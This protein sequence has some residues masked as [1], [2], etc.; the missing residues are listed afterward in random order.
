MRIESTQT[1]GGQPK[2]I[3][4]DETASSES[5]EKKYL[6]SLEHSPRA[7]AHERQGPLQEITTTKVMHPCETGFHAYPQCT[8]T[9]YKTTGKKHT[10][11]EPLAALPLR[12]NT[13]AGTVSSPSSS[14]S[15]S[16]LPCH[17]GRGGTGGGARGHVNGDGHL[18]PPRASR[19]HKPIFT[20]TFAF[21]FT[22]TFAPVGLRRRNSPAP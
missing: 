14:S 5:P 6:I 19:S 16:L 8:R 3:D 10:I 4:R 1:E 18:L 20:P 21:S 17:A 12:S 22:F 2:A 7:C 13:Y 15:P 11:V 9:V